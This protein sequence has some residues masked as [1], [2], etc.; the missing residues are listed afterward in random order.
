MDNLN[1]LA[2]GLKILG[3]QTAVAVFGAMF[4]AQNAMTVQALD[5][6]FL[7]DFAAVKQVEVFDGVA[8]P[9]N[10]F[11][12]VLGEQVFGRRKIEV[13]FVAHSANCFGEEGQVLPFGKT[14]E[15]RYIVD[16]RVHY[17]SH[18]TVAQQVEKL[19]RGFVRKAD[20][21]DVYHLSL[22]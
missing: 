14:C 4:A 9:C 11:V 7:S 3:Q 2:H 21:I 10:F 8:F 18:S 16:A 13:V 6:G 20:G 12:A 15:L 17:F 19:P 1:I 22:F 5:V